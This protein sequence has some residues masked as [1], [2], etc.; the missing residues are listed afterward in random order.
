MS[1]NP[2]SLR[3]KNILVTGAS[4][5]I[6]QRTAIECSKMGAS[7]IITGRDKERLQKTMNEL[8]TSN[9]QNHYQI[10]ADITTDEG[11]NA[12]VSQ[13]SGIDGFVSCA[14][15]V[16]SLPAQFASRD[17]IDDIFGVNFLSPVELLRQLYKKKL[18]EKHASIVA[19]SALSGIERF[20]SRNSVYGASKAALSS[21]MKFCA[22]EFAPRGI[23]V[24]CVCPGMVD[25]PLI[26]N[27]S[28]TDEQLK[29]DEEKYPL[30]RYG[31][32]DDIAFMIIYLLSDAASWVTGQ[33]FIIDG[34]SSIK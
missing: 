18:L 10:I 31:T 14:G 2:F 26:H 7:L 33:N 3:G 11:Q 30:K 4:S 20:S 24:N 29:A 15:K 32:P 13:L 12:L 25:T 19:V 6:G 28:V 16:L 27:G 17:R 9:G 5:G 23:R 21:F 34:G 8:E 1:Y 22:L